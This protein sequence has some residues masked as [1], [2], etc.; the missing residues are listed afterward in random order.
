[1]FLRGGHLPHVGAPPIPVHLPLLG[2]VFAMAAKKLRAIFVK[3]SQLQ[4]S[5][6]PAAICSSI[7]SFECL[8]HHLLPG[9]ASVCVPVCVAGLCRLMLAGGIAICNKSKSAAAA[10]TARRL[11]QLQVD[12]QTRLRPLPLPLSLSAQARIP[13]MLFPPPYS[14]PR[15]TTT[16][17]F[18]SG[19]CA[20]SGRK[21]FGHGKQTLEFIKSELRCPELIKKQER[22]VTFNIP[23]NLY[24]Y[25]SV[26]F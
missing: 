24:S 11:Q 9:C 23:K 6:S 8:H 18:N 5:C 15:P 3:H 19:M 14:G 16:H 1:M 20:V 21:P 7:H 26:K 12:T 25:S 13:T 4:P 17:S 2:D 22:R 10:A